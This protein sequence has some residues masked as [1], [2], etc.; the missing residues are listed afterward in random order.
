M[1]ILLFL[2]LVLTVNATIDFTSIKLNYPITGITYIDNLNLV[3][4]STKNSSVVTFHFE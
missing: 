4:I 2:L 1:K 3:A